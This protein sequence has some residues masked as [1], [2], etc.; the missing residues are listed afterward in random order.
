M[1]KVRRPKS[2]VVVGSKLLEFLRDYYDEEDEHILRSEFMMRMEHL[3]MGD[4]A[5]QK[6]LSGGPIAKVNS[7]KFESFYKPGSFQK[8]TESYTQ[9]S[10]SHLAQWLNRID[11]LYFMPL[12]EQNAAAAAI[13]TIIELLDGC[14]RHIE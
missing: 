2:P 10:A 11:Q 14:G 13:P 3:E 4:K 7:D 6:F 8:I 5:V 1:A 12:V 9:S